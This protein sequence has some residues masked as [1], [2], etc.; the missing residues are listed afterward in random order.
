[1]SITK[2][3]SIH[4]NVL[5]LDH[6]RQCNFDAS[7]LKTAKYK[8]HIWHVEQRNFYETVHNFQEPITNTNSFM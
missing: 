7:L 5:G 8:K 6:K 4:V 3:T 2:I 1:M